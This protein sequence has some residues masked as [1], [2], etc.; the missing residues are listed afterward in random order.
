MDEQYTYVHI[1]VYASSPHHQASLV[2][3]TQ[4]LTTPNS[5]PVSYPALPCILS[6][7]TSASTTGRQWSACL[8]QDS[9]FQTPGWRPESADTELRPA[10]ARGIPDLKTSAMRSE[11]LVPRVVPIFKCLILNRLSQHF[12]ESPGDH[13]MGPGKSFQSRAKTL[14]RPDLEPGSSLTAHAQSLSGQYK[15]TCTPGRSSAD[16]TFRSVVFISVSV[17]VY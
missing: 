9:R 4:V 1:P 6:V 8:T 2:H 14:W 12:R 7:S 5:P 10:D 13:L 3:S 17:L 11:T 15:R 16:L